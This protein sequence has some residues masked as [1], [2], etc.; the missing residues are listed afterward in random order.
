MLTFILCVLGGIACV[1]IGF[2]LSELKF[3]KMVNDGIIVFRYE[4][5]GEEG[6]DGTDEAIEDI[7]AWA[8]KK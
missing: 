7:K 6:W 1:A 5:D 4:D 3:G 2:A 8:K